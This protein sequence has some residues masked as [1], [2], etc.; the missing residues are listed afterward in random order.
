MALCDAVRHIY[1]YRQPTAGAPPDSQ[2]VHRPTGKRL[3]SIAKQQ[4][5]SLET[6]EAFLGTIATDRLLLIL[7][8]TSLYAIIVNHS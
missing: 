2:L 5:V 6:N 3:G 4:V 1:I 8:S 7:T